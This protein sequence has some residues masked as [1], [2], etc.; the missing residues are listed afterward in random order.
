MLAK[1][2]K[3]LRRMI[4]K[5]AGYLA[6]AVAVICATVTM[7]NVNRRSVMLSDNDG[8]HGIDV[9][10]HQGQIDWNQV[11]KN[12]QVGFVYLKATEGKG[13]VDKRYRENIRAVRSVGIPVG[14]YHFFI[15]RKTAEEQYANFRSVVKRSQQDL[16]PVVDVEE[17]GNRHISRQVLQ[18]RLSRFMEL[19]KRDYG[20]YPVLYS[21]YSFY[22]KMLAPEFNKYY[23]F[24]ARYSKQK[25]TIKG[26]GKYNIWQYSERGQIDGI[27]ERVDLDRLCNG[28]TLESI[29]LK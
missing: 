5:N 9:S 21:Q 25:P 20:R 23:L 8:Y 26:G 1:V 24:I 27:S 3:L 19:V 29:R 16:L 11:A 28:T 17:S 18:Q 6:L 22:N 12:R 14:S 2:K 13:N 10:W 15:G 4:R 7:K